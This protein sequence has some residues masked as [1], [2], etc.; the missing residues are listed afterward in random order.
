[1]LIEV[2][3]SKFLIGL[4]SVLQGSETMETPLQILQKSLK[5]RRFLDAPI[6]SN[7][8]G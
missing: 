4:E 1:M 5:T 2:G 6:V 7:Q 3:G 8:I